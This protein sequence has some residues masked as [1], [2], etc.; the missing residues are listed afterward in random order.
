MSLRMRLLAFCGCALLLGCSPAEDAGKTLVR[1]AY[2]GG[3]EEVRIIQD[4]VAAWQK[5]HPG[6]HVSLEHAPG[7]SYVEKLLTQFAG[8]AGPDIV[9]AEINVFVPFYSK[10]VL[11]DL[12]AFIERDPAFRLEDFFPGVVARFRRNGGVYCIPRDTAPMCVVYYNKKL[13][14]AAGVPYPSDD[15]TW[16]D[17]LVKARAL[18]VRD[19]ARVKQYGFSTGLWQNFVYGHGG[20]IVD[21]VEHPTRCLLD[22]PEAVAGMQF[23]HDLMY[24]HGVAPS[25]VAAAAMGMSEHELFAAQ[26]VAMFAS[27]IWY[28]PT[29]RLIDTLDWDVAMFPKGPTGVRAFTTGGSGYAMAKSTRNPDAAWEVLKCLAGDRG[30]IELAESGLAQPANRRIA[31]SQHWAGSPKPPLNKKMLNEAVNYVIYDPLHPRWQQIN[32]QVIAQQLELLWNGRQTV[33]ET[34]SNIAA[35]ATE[36]LQSP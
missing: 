6:I 1:V 36:M 10:G 22:Q 5:D 9:F 18:T 33:G 30:Q 12:S 32:Q 19:G 15:W 17:L 25:P 7:G 8:G 20:R 29:F 26:R 16:E 14:D 3:P 2:W 21:S 27:G 31:E 4:T 35:R 34:C 24:K 13:F 23:F 11:A 28:T